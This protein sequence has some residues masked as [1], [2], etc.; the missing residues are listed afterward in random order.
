MFC[1][2]K[3]RDARGARRSDGDATTSIY[4]E[5]DQEGEDD[6]ACVALTDEERAGV[7]AQKGGKTKRRVSRDKHVGI[8]S[9]GN[10]LV[11]DAK[12][13]SKSGGVVSHRQQHVAQV[14]QQQQKRKYFFGKQQLPA[15]VT[16]G[17]VG[18]ETSRSKGRSK[19]ARLRGDDVV[20]RS[21]TTN[22]NTKK[23]RKAALHQGNMLNNNVQ[24]MNR[25]QNSSPSRNNNNGT[26]S[27]MILQKCESTMH[28]N[29]R[30]DMYLFLP[31]S[32]N[33]D[34][35]LNFMDVFPNSYRSQKF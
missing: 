13:R 34:R 3:Q 22:G 20:G 9:K 24:K 4:L 6:D 2:L 23:S 8:D 16:G 28:Y 26:K 1:C 29:Q 33:S 25:N 11:G 7:E 21:L 15:G 5:S 18:E 30:A 14:R 31:F 32:F 19:R 10:I 27:D 17:V 12:P 35:Q